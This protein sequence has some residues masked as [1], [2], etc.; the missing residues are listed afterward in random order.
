MEE[1]GLAGAFEAH[2]GIK[3]E[4]ED[5][6]EIE[7]VAKSRIGVHRL[8]V[9]PDG[10]FFRSCFKIDGEKVSCS[11]AFGKSRHGR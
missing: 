2:F 7:K 5:K 1:S 6:M 10:L 11:P 8:I 9:Y 4:I 3:D